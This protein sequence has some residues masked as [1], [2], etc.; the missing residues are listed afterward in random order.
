MFT[1]VNVLAGSSAIGGA[2]AFFAQI[3]VSRQQ[4]WYDET[5]EEVAR[6]RLAKRVRDAH[7][8]CGGGGACI[9]MSC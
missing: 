4:K 9:A 1:T 6:D 5:E 8:A 3:I 7:A 2:L